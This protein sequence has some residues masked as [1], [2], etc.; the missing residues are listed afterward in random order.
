M[1]TFH[2]LEMAKQ[3]LFAQRSA[4]HTTGHNISNANTEGY[5]RQRVNFETMSPYPAGARNRPEIPGQIGTGVEAGSIERVR[6]QFLDKQ[7]RAE[8]SKAGYWETKSDA[9][10]RMENL[11]NEP[12]ES[13]LSH[14]MDQFWQAIQELAVNPDNSGARSVVAQRGLAVS[15]TF[16]YLADSLTSIRSDLETQIEITVMDANSIIGDIDRVNK[17]INQLEP[18]GYL[19][20]DLYDERDRLMDKLS[21]MMNI[22]TG[23]SVNGESYPGTIEAVDNEGKSF[24]PPVILVN[25]E[26]GEEGTNE[27][28]VEPP[29]NE[30]TVVNAEGE[31]RN[32]TSSNGSITG[33]IEAYGHDDNEDAVNLK[34]MLDDLDEMAVTFA[35]AFNEVHR[36]GYGLD[37]SKENFFESEITGAA[38]LTVREEILNN[39]DKIAASADGTTGNGANASELADIFN[40]R[41]LDGAPLGENTSVN[42][43]NQSLI[44]KLGVAA[45]EANRMTNNTE[46]LRT[47]VENQRMSVSS[48]SLDEEMSNM[49]KF[50]HAYNASARS[51]TAMDELLDRIINN[52]GLVG[53]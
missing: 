53:R 21:S 32:I 40:D 45:Q 14:T 36:E 25:G 4:L 20:N 30:I 3:A 22:K 44:S 18:H 50:Q 2:G 27:I 6:D 1:S 17:Q 26:P 42:S 33:L 31:P 49:I 34:S 24:E 37:G 51:M 29:Y 7:Y 19:P 38:D 5:S 41:D 28:K 9:L 47:Q 52:M 39:P 23:A 13:G 46:I 43:F 8:N 12:S 35:E 16:N 48:V 10:A 15:E 11:M